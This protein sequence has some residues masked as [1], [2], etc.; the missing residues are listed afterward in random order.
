MVKNLR[1]LRAKKW[2]P[3]CFAWEYFSRRELSVKLEKMA[4]NSRSESHAH[5][6]ST[7]VFFIIKDEARFYLGDEE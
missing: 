2:A 1:N 6:V 4:P 5:K 7:Q 3:G